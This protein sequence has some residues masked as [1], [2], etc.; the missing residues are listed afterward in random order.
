MKKM[1]ASFLLCAAGFLSANADEIKLSIPVEFYK[2]GT[3]EEYLMNGLYKF[4]VFDKIPD[5]NETANGSGLYARIPGVLI[6]FQGNTSG[7]ILDAAGKELPAFPGI[8]ASSWKKTK[9]YALYEL[10]FTAP[11]TEGEL[12]LNIAGTQ[13]K[14]DIYLNGQK[15]GTQGLFSNRY[16]PIS[17]LIRKNGSNNLKIALQCFYAKRNMFGT[18][19]FTPVAENAGIVHDIKLITLQNKLMLRVTGL[20]TSI[21]DKEAVFSVKAY[22]YSNEEKNVSL[23]LFLGKGK[24]A[25]FNK[26]YDT[27][28]P[29]GESIHELKVPLGKFK[30]W[31]PESPELYM[32]SLR[33]EDRNG[34]ILY[35]IK[36][37]ETG[38]RE[39]AYSGKDLL[40]N[41]HIVTLFGD[42]AARI[43]L[44]MY[45]CAGTY[46][47]DSVKN[48]KALGF[49]FTNLLEF[50]TQPETLKQADRYGLMLMP[51]YR[52][53]ADEIFQN[54]ARFPGLTSLDGKKIPAEEMEEFKT[55]FRDFTE[56]FA[57][58][59]SVIGYARF[60]NWLC[61]CEKAYN[62]H[63]A[64]LKEKTSSEKVDFAEA[65]MKE[66]EKID[67]SK[68]SYY[69]HAGGRGTVYTHNRYWS[70]GVPLQEKSD[71]L[72]LWSEN[73]SSD[74]MP[75][76]V[77]EGFMFSG[78]PGIYPK[79]GVSP[80]NPAWKGF[81]A[82]YMTREIG[83][84]TEGPDAY[85]TDKLSVKA[86]HSELARN[87]L[88]ETSAYRYYG[89]M[90]HLL[91]TDSYE[92]FK[93]ATPY[94]V[95]NKSSDN[96][97]G[98]VSKV[99][100]WG[101]QYPSTNLTDVGRMF[102]HCFS[103]FTFFI[104]GDKKNPTAVEHNV[105]AGSELK[106]SLLVINETGAEKDIRIKVAASVDGKDFYTKTFRMDLE[107]GER[108]L[109]PFSIDIPDLKE[110]KTAL[111][112]AVLEDKEPIAAP[113]FEITIFPESASTIKAKI[114]YYDESDSLKEMLAKYD[115]KGE[116]LQ[117]LKK[118]DD[119]KL[120]VVGCDSLSI[121]FSKTAKELKLA[122]W[123]EN[124][125]RIIVLEQN[126]P[127]FMNLK[128]DAR[129]ARNA[130]ITNKN[131]PIFAGMTDKDFSNWTGK[132]SL[133]Q[134]FPP[135]EIGFHWSNP[136][137]SSTSGVV[138]SLP[139]EKPHC[140]AFTPLLE[141]G[142]DLQFSPLMEAV[143][144]KGLLL[145]SQ[146]DFKGRIGNDP[147]ATK[148][149]GNMLA[150]AL[151]TK[152]PSAANWTYVGSKTGLDFLKSELCDTAKALPEK[153]FAKADL[154]ILGPDADKSISKEEIE[155]SLKRGASVL[156]LPYPGIEK[157]LPVPVSSFKLNTESA[158]KNRKE[159][160]ESP[161]NLSI[162]DLWWHDKIAFDAWKLEKGNPLA[163]IIDY[164]K[165]KIVYCRISP[166]DL[167]NHYFKMKAYRVWSTILNK[168]N[169]PAKSLAQDFYTC[170][171]DGN[172]KLGN[173]ALFITDPEDKGL[174]ASWMKP[175]YATKDWKK[176]VVPGAWEK[177]PY[178]ENFGPVDPVPAAF[179]YNG[180]AWYRFS[181]VIPERFK[182]FTTLLHLGKIDD[183]DTTWVNG[184]KVGMTN[185]DSGSNPYTISRVYRVPEKLIKYGQENQITI[186]VEDIQG[187]GGITAGPLELEFISARKNGSEYYL[188]DSGIMEV[189]GVSPYYNEQW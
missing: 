51:V 65:V 176:I 80:K 53:D 115:I 54:H 159:A 148:C 179:N 48:L 129:R 162:S 118:L 97:P 9:A 174:A 93:G 112:S 99:L 98:F 178:L 132:S 173:S 59:P 144:G 33:A 139:F 11:A 165:G 147:A 131:H 21:A 105:F 41:G 26:T 171:D 25:E 74:K 28:L 86:L 92:G 127:R 189:F 182:G 13:Y 167:K 37:A 145:M 186:R 64:G 69:H 180:I 130:F 107:P 68:I 109:I 78:Y 126:A 100:I 90:G 161:L 117:T 49:N 15:L 46:P 140:G 110:K 87:I 120:L 79:W 50:Q 39:L 96:V 183:H 160:E 55:Q 141:S 123:L 45:Q 66:S 32:L 10:D 119:I 20:K 128:T 111:I 125:G 60:F 116:K 149:F 136:I 94:P 47:E 181:V 19:G 18:D 177:T 91:H 67:S 44:L 138:S 184:V 22:N 7:Q 38:F 164:E 85:F 83:A 73:R 103:G 30:L 175:D 6:D 34:K 72:K 52:P 143:C 61:D 27:K 114:A 88:G 75:Y 157:L 121:N 3:S 89:V 35:A 95:T 188:K 134:E 81:A 172:I 158:W 36:D 24:T 57:L 104:M 124:G 2:S 185:K 17:K 155:K 62:P 4:K 137:V 31:E 153:E 5:Q 56:Y 168:L 29:P 84:I 58:S 152:I 135:A 76:M 77:T 106:K 12:L 82:P 8:I 154:L 43:N 63:L 101:S 71:F 133:L 16:Y 163:G 102:K 1:L 113:P 187:D 40:L 142:Y 156:V 169:V 14:A 150:Y 108:K 42:S 166:D 23:K 70:C 151:D 170:R 122:D 146:L